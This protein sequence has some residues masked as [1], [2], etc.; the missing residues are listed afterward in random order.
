MRKRFIGGI[1]DLLGFGGK[2]E[3]L[4][5]FLWPNSKNM[6]TSLDSFT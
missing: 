4:T 3:I 2:D 5:W 6:L 1:K